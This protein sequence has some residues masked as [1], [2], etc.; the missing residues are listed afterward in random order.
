[1]TAAAAG[2]TIVPELAGAVRV[3]DDDQRWRATL[4]NELRERAKVERDRLAAGLS[5]IRERGTADPASL[6]T[7]LDVELHALSLRTTE[8]L[9]AAARG[10][11]SAVFTEVV[12]GRLTEAVRAR[13]LTAVRRNL[14]PDDRTLLVTAT[15][16]VAVVS[17]AAAALSASGAPVVTLLPPIGVAVSGSC[18]LTWQRRLALDEAA[19][20]RWLDRAVR[21]LDAQLEDVLAARFAALAEAVET[22]AADAV[23]HGVLL[24]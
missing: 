22:L 7:R 24:A 10:L 23:D 5:A 2:P 16:G 18:H 15:A 13:I 6:A 21:A 9:D 14:E 8:A 19:G 17:G 3:T 12:A 1:M 20:R 11:V 4:A